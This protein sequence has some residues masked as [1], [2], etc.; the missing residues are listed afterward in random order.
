MSLH[1]LPIKFTGIALVKPLGRYFI[2]KIYSTKKLGKL[3]LRAMTKDHKYL[4]NLSHNGSIEMLF[5]LKSYTLSKI[6]HL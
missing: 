1:T 3:C 5:F 6:H 4:K 2:F